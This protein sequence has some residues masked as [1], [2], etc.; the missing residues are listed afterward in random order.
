MHSVLFRTSCPP[1]TEF[2]MQKT[3]APLTKPEAAPV[4]LS[5]EQLQAVS[6]GLP[7][8]GW[9]TEGDTVVAADAVVTVAVD[10][11]PLPRGGW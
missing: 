6:G 7:R 1:P 8:G 10:P 4:E 2:I 3:Q 9:G 11:T 5:M